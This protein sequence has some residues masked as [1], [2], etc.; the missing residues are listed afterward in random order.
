MTQN[1]SVRSRLRTSETT[2]LF[3]NAVI[4]GHATEGYQ[5]HVIL[6]KS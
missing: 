4:L 1:V 2:Y 5:G 6:K 3:M